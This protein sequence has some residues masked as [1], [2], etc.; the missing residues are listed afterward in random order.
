LLEQPAYAQWAGLME[1][2]RAAAA[3]CALAEGR[4]EARGELL[5]VAQRFS[6]RLGVPLAPVLGPDAPIVVTGH[7]PELYHPGVWVKDFLLQRFAREQRATAI[8]IVVDTDGFDSIGITTPCF[9]PHVERCHAYLAVGKTDGYYAGA[10]VPSDEDIGQFCDLAAEHVA[11]LPAPAVGVH[12]SAFCEQL[13]SAAGD[14]HDLAELVTF[15]RRRYEASA[16][17]DYLEL[18][19]TQMARTKSYLRFVAG[20]VTNAEGFASAY[21]DALAEYRRLHGVRSAAQ[22]LPDLETGEIATELPFWGLSDGRRFRL[23]AGLAFDGVSIQDESGGVLMTLPTGLMSHPPD[24]AEMLA[25]SH[26]TFA[27]K[28]LA[29]TMFVRLYLADF[30]IH[31]VG[32][33]RYDRVTDAI[34]AGYYRLEPPAFAVASATMYL[35]LGAHVVSD[36]ELAEAK[37]RLNRLEHNPDALLAEIEFDS[38]AERDAALTLA[39]EK[40]ELVARIA[41]PDADKKALGSRIREVNAELSELLAPLRAEFERVLGELE[42]LHAANDV[43][44]DRTYPFCFW[45]PEE[46]ADKIG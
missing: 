38:A 29:L 43:L 6:A 7:Q 13:R 21:N 30:F 46:V 42:A 8:D 44:T 45:S 3:S 15:A 26:I 37:D 2:N 33:G 39:A 12:F 14:A 4:A 11:T 25:A 36:E 1:A 23:Y 16:R 9:R 27:P 31:G 18:P 24:Y 17:T 41:R 40:A 35:P 19:V 22:P 28:A 34:I 20:I 5:E 10:P 32:G